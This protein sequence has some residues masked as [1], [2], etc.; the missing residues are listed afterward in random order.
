MEIGS[1][2]LEKV[3][4]IIPQSASLTFDVFHMVDEDADLFER[5]GR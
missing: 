2:G 1:E 4:L 3:K 5:I